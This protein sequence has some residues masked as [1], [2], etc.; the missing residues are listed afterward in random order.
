MASQQ[1][2]QLEEAEEVRQTHSLRAGSPRPLSPRV[3][4]RLSGHV[5]VVGDLDGARRST[6]S[7]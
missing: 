1:L 5:V 7:A 3:L 6:F 4:R 2:V